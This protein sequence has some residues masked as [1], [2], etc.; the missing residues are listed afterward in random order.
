MEKVDFKILRA[1]PY[2]LFTMFMSIMLSMAG[3]LIEI[4]LSEDPRDIII[5][6]SNLNKY[7]NLI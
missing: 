6:S 3:L 2:A 7:L 5:P 1:F 4:I